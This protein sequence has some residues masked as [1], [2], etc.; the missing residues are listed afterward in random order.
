MTT[1]GG[2]VPADRQEGKTLQSSV[3]RIVNVLMAGGNPR[4]IASTQAELAQVLDIDPAALNRALRGGRRWSIED[5]ANLADHFGVSVSIFFEDPSDL[6]KL[7]IRSRC[8]S[9]VILQMEDPDVIDLRDRR[10][11][12]RESAHAERWT[13]EEAG[14]R[15][16]QT[17]Y[18]RSLAPLGR[19][20]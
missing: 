3:S 12:Y 17:R 18:E 2:A 9:D 7:Q 13:P 16:D 10:T 6:F 20:S 15:V 19:R 1:S 11:G 4:A 8:S 5:I 14:V